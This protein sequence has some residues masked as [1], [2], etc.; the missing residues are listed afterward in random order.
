M[1][2]ERVEVEEVADV[3]VLHAEGI[4]VAVALRLAARA[5]VVDL[6]EK[7]TNE[8]RER[9]EFLHLCSLYG[10]LRIGVEASCQIQLSLIAFWD[11]VL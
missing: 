3:N 2:A 7:G 11:N 5:V 10:F 4:L 6:R 8:V 1:V 9:I